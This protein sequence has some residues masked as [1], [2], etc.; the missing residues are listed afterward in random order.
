MA[1]LAHKKLCN[2]AL[3]AMDYQTGE[4]VAY[5]GSADPT[6][7]KA[8]KQFQPRFDVL[9]DG[10][11]QPGSAFKPIVYATGHRG[12]A[13]HRRL[14]VHGRRHGLRRWLHAGGRRRLERGPVRARDALR[15]SLNIPGRQGDGSDRQ[16]TASRPAPRRWASSSGAARRT[17]AW[18]SRWAWRR[19]G[20]WTWSAPTAMLANGGVLVPRTTILTVTSNA[21]EVI[22]GPET[23]PDP[24]AGA[25]RRHGVHPHGHPGRQHGSQAEPVLGQ[26]RDP[27]RRQA[28]A[29]H[30]QDGHQQRR[31]GPQR[32]RL[33]RRADRGGAW[34]R[35]IRAGGRRV[36]RQLRQ[37]A[38]EHARRPGASRS[39]SRRTSGRGSSR[40]RPRAGGST[41]SRRPDGLQQATVDPWTGLLAGPGATRTVDELFLSGTAPTATLPQDARCGEAV[42]QNAGFEKDH[43]G[44]L[45]ADRAWLKRA[46]RGAGVRGGPRE[47]PDRLL[48][49][50]RVQPV[51]PLL[52][53]PARRGA[54]VR[55]A[56]AQR[57]P[58]PVCLAGPAGI[59][60][61]V[62]HGRPAGHARRL[63]LAVRDSV[64][65]TLPDS[66]P[67]PDARALGAAHPDTGAIA[68]T[69]PGADG[70]THRAADRAA[71]ARPFGVL[72]SPRDRRLSI[73]SGNPPYHPGGRTG[74]I[75]AH[76][77]VADQLTHP[78]LGDAHVGSRFRAPEPSP[79][80]LPGCPAPRHPRPRRRSP[81]PGR[82]CRR[83]R[84]RDH[85][86]PGRRGRAGLDAPRSSSSSTFPPPS[87]WTSRPR[88]FRRAGPPGS[89]AGAAR[90]T[91]PTWI[92]RRRP[93]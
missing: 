67:E 46:A 92:R 57:D 52:G 35:A 40:R 93:R 31:P 16:R 78:S 17:P 8:T 44:W 56:V 90:S 38:R 30:A 82:R 3:V 45:A 43:E 41:G 74:G 71:D 28:A 21:G 42:L 87:G 58:G 18:P 14:D 29:G 55:H 77:V 23:R 73:L 66:R 39:T 19:S 72:T 15:F 65:L 91:V 50:R 79:S 24:R 26:V 11:R 22:L 63:P 13:H 2:G 37:L 83:R 33:H 59:R 70:A 27:R 84:D 25:G 62:R 10:W 75:P 51:W 53:P 69:H 64:R 20:P 9:A 85:A 49:Q 89:A 54:G 48:L 34:R 1:N 12:P 80:G 81:R 76:P 86:V 36:E 32:V 7:T 88:A 61:S 4:L 5:V 68:D 60:R 6:A 47:H